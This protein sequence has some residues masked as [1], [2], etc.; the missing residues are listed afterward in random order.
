M[1]K[2]AAGGDRVVLVVATRGERGDAVGLRRTSATRRAAVEELERSASALGVARVEV[3][4]YG[5]S[6]SGA[7]AAAS[8]LLR[9]RADR[10]GAAR[11]WRRSCAKRRPTS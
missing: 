7:G 5:D 3:L 10:R 6:G 11:A 4:G 8:G 2:A 9:R 1:A